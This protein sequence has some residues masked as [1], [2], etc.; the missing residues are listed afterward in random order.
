MLSNQATIDRLSN[1]VLHDLELARDNS[2]TEEEYQLW[3]DRIEALEE[4][5]DALITN[6]SVELTA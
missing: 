6:N 2:E 4:T 3:E 1:E 5:I